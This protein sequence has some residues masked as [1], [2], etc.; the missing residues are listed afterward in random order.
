MSPG[1]LAVFAYGSLVSAA[2]AAETLG[3]DPA[4]EWPDGAAEPAELAGWRRRWSQARD[5]RRCE[6]TFA[7][8]GDG[9]IPDYVLGLNVERTGN[10]RDVVNGLL[11]TLTPDELDR[12]DVRELRYDRVDVS[13]EILPRATAGGYER[14]FTYEAKPEQL[15]L[16]APEGAVILAAYARAVES[17]FDRLGTGQRARFLESTDPYPVDRVEA[18]LVRDEIPAGNPRGW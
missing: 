10:P 9:W 1:P 12:L 15:V 13:A 14:V 11:I 3:R 8:D 4:E 18:H 2:S 17:A 16:E 6:K 7:R 5:N